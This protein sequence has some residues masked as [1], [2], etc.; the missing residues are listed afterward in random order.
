MENEY[1][2]KVRLDHL[3]Y[4]LARWVESTKPVDPADLRSLKNLC[5]RDQDDKLVVL[6]ED[7]YYLQRLQDRYPEIKLK[8]SWIE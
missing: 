5:V 7:S 8:I 1:G 6:F 4:H 3:P 2:A